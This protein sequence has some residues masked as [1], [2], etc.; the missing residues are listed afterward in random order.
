MDKKKAPKN[1]DVFSLIPE[2]R[3]RN[4]TSVLWLLVFGVFVLCFL[5]VATWYY[6]RHTVYLFHFGKKPKCDYSPLC[7]GISNL[8]KF[9]CHPDPNAS[10]ESCLQRGCCYQSNKNDISVNSNLN[11]P[12]CFYP[13]NYEGYSIGNITQD[14][15][16]IRA[17]L[18]RDSPSGFPND[19]L[20]LHLVISFIDDCTLRI[21]ITDPNSVRFE[22]PMPINDA[23]KNLNK[24][25]YD[26]K[27]DSKTGQLVISRK[28]TGTIIFK[29]NLSQLVYS[30]Q[31]LQLSSYLPS[32]YLYGIG[33]HYSS[34]LRNVNWTRLTLLNSDR[35]P[36][37]N[38]PL[39]GSHPFYLSLE[40]D[41]NANGVFLLNSNAMDVILQPA[42]A[43]T[44]RPIGGILD[45]FVM[46]GP[47]PANVVQQYTDIIGRTFMPPY[48]SLGFQLCRYGYGSLN[49]TK[50]TLMRNLKAGIPVDVQWNDIDYMDGRKDF[51]Y[52]QDKFSALPEFVDELH[53]KGMH[54]VIMTDPG[55]SCSEKP[56]T[57]PPYDDGLTDDIFI[58]NPNGTIFRGKVW[59]DGETVYPD[60]S[61]PKTDAY[62]LRHFADFHNKVKFDGVWIDMNEPSNFYDGGKDGCMKSSFE[63]PP[64]LPNWEQGNIPLQHKTICMTA[65]HYSTIHYNEHNLV[66]YREATA[67]YR[68]L[69]GIRQKRP[70]IISRASFSGLGNQSG[71][72]SGDISSTWED[73]RYTIPSMLNFN[74][75]GI[76]MVGSDICGFN[77]D[78]TVPLC[79]RWQSLGA[80]YPFSRNHNT[81]GAKEQDPAILGPTVITATVNSL[82]IRYLLL[83]YLYTLFA[84][85]HVFG[86]TVAR[87]L[88]FEF[89]HDKNTYSIDEQFLWG[90]G[91]MVN[92]VVY[93]N[94]TNVTAYF[95]KGRW[96]DNVGKLINSSGQR[97]TIQ[98]PIT[99]VSIA[100][101]G[102]YILPAQLPALNTELSRQQPFVLMGGLD[103]N[104]QA[105][106][107]LYWDDGDS[108]DT[109]VKGNYTLI[110]INVNNNT[111]AT[112]VV[113]K[114]YD[115]PMDLGATQIA[116]IEKD[117]T[118]V[119]VN[120][121]NC[122]RQ[123]SGKKEHEMNL[124]NPS[125]II[126]M[127]RG[128]KSKDPFCV[129]AYIAHDGVSIG[130]NGFSL[131]S[132]ITITWR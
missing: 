55:I 11:V 94:A 73:L 104:L 69:K 5:G 86:D 87:P 65:K 124:F 9:D 129:Y 125:N 82:Y 48:W 7:T 10:K 105:T 80:F 67:T 12:Y 20:S 3:P 56:G 72:W 97:I 52:D 18:K 112:T 81:L 101:R 40:E 28:A 14:G 132:P 127:V 99:E 115:G 57:Y 85:S 83:P 8:D 126:D 102:G 130:T 33:E 45:F 70:F 93:E 131:L 41:G 1:D 51:T 30:D 38:Y 116:G 123:P 71:H 31:F 24:P 32:P 36:L 19:I 84:R 122:K 74:L 113:N 50:E 92:P 100:I 34:L 118:E 6:G 117:P 77:Q 108:L 27:I 26:V 90:S 88:F 63:D 107:E 43:I 42:P 35:G 89:P 13:S 22:V 47:S 29:T 15:R 96:Y 4:K 76:P 54:Y 66:A 62:W 16:H 75:Y 61:N 109:Y 114:G 95:P 119:T 37:A 60:F 110:R 79:A 128:I 98:V 53:S 103:E 17:D 49:T 78:T 46:L 39:Y 25:C 120:G 2:E 111:L 91:L 59:T 68:A 21:K 58:K 121:V 23:L 106:G 44:F 64:Y